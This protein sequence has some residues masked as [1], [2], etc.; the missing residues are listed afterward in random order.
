M[1]CCASLFYMHE[2]SQN[3]NTYFIISMRQHHSIYIIDYYVYKLNKT[4]FYADIWI[5]FKKEI[6][7]YPLKQKLKTTKKRYDVFTNQVG[8]FMHLSIN[9]P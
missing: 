1:I 4:K 5:E 8:L 3:Y 6:H 7:V 9:V 2:F